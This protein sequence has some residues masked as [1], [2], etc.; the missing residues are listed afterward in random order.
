MLAPR[1]VW[2]SPNPPHQSVSFPKSVIAERLIRPSEF[3]SLTQEAAQSVPKFAPSPSELYDSI[4]PWGS[5]KSVNTWLAG[6]APANPAIPD[7]FAKVE[8]WYADEAQRF[9]TEFGQTGSL[10]KGWQV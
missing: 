10:I 7:W 9:E 8:F 6:V 3:S 2:V 4:R 5:L 1:G